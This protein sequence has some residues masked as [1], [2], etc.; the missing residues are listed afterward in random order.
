MAVPFVKDDIRYSADVVLAGGVMQASLLDESRMLPLPPAIQYRLNRSPV[1][2]FVTVYTPELFVTVA[3][4]ECA[5][6]S[7]AL[8]LG[9]V[10]STHSST[11]KDVV[12]KNDVGAS[13]RVTWLL[14]WPMVICCTGLVQAA[15]PLDDRQT[16][17]ARKALLVEFTDPVSDKPIW[18]RDQNW[19]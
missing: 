13:P 2:L 14:V 18:S 7:W 19:P 17:S 6:D 10:S 12:P 9:L 15:P 11:P 5:D 4:P 3:V 16:S 1:P 8:S